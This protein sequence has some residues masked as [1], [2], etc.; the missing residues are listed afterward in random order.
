MDRLSSRASDLRELAVAQ[1][2]FELGHQFDIK[3]LTRFLEVCTYFSPADTYSL[4]VSFLGLFPILMSANETLKREAI[5][6]LETGGLFAFA[7]S[8][9][10]HGADLFGNEFVVTMEL[11]KW[12]TNGTKYYI[13]NV[14]SACIISVLAKDGS[15][16]VSKR[17]P[18]IFFALRPQESSGF[19]NPHKIRTLGIRTAY[20]GGFEVK[21]HHF[22][23]SDLLSQRRDAWDAVFATVNL[24]KFFLGFGSIGICQHAFV[25]AYAHA[26]ANALRETCDR[27]AARSLDEHLRVCSSDG[28]EVLRVPGA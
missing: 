12:V 14:N 7:V 24:G 21:D 28:D 8:E 4:H 3:K 25:E 6:R 13:G 16:G 10:T 22:P 1:K 27:N 9:K 26:R 20:V 2:L 18:F 17:A 19:Q 11:G 23:E 5:A 15:E